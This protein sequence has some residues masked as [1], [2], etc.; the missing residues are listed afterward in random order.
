MK[1]KEKSKSDEKGITESDVDPKVLKMGI[2]VEY[3]HTDKI[4]KW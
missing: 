3:E 1:L 2:E 4:R